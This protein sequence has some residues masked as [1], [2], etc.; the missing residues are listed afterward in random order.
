M[1]DLAAW[2]KTHTPEAALG[3]AGIIIGLIAIKKKS[4]GSSAPLQ[5]S[6]INTSSTDL[7]SQLEAQITALQNPQSAPT[8]S[9]YVIPAGL[10]EKGSGFVVPGTAGLVERDASGHSYT[11]VQTAAEARAARLAGE[12]LYFQP[13]PG[14]FSLTKGKKLDKGTPQ[15]VRIP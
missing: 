12:A 2:A 11:Y 6:A 3:A 7:Y 9:G 1:I 10:V 5:S 8:G 13:T 14:Q 15:F 4:S